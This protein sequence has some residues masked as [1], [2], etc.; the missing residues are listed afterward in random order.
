MVA[1][2]CKF[3]RWSCKCSDQPSKLT[4]RGTRPPIGKALPLHFI[5]PLRGLSPESLY[6]GGTKGHHHCKVTYD[7]FVG[8]ERRVVPEVQL[9][10]RHCIRAVLDHASRPTAGC[11]ADGQASACAL[12]HAGYAA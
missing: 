6:D 7:S 1:G 11:V 5:V 10:E 4:S 12:W 2:S 9:P 8:T 3:G